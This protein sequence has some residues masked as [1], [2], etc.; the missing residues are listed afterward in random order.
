MELDFQNELERTTIHAEYRET[1]NYIY[2]EFIGLQSLPVLKEAGEVAL[3][4]LQEKACTKILSNN[5]GMLGGKDFAY[6]YILTD[7]A[8]RAISYGLK[9][10]AYVMPSA[11]GNPQTVK[12][13][14][15]EFPPEIKFM[16]FDN[17]EDARHW[18]LSK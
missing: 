6:D 9:Y 18:L 5:S 14:E 1:D 11:P 12:K 4:I 10:F 7:F 15:I 2:A 13:L 8:P 3:R 16:L 17:V